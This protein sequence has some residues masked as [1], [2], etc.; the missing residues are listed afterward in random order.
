MLAAGAA[1]LGGENVC[2]L[3]IIGPAGGVSSAP[4]FP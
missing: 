2:S 3:P 4:S 1:G